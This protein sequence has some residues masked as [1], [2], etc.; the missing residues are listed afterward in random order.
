MNRWQFSQAAR[1]LH[2]GGLIAY[3]TE[4]VWGLGCDPLNIHSVERLLALKARPQ[5]KGLI[6]I[7]AELAQIAPFIGDLTLDERRM[8]SSSGPRAITW[9]VPAS[10]DCPPWLRGRHSTIAIRLTGHSLA[11]RL[12]RAFGGAI[13]ST[14]ANPSGLPAATRSLM[15]RR[16]FGDTIDFLCPGEL[17]GARRASEIRDL[18]SGAVIRAGG[19]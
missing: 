4:A 15:V 13:V 5:S 19:S 11:A 6:L 1:V 9:L 2:A 3:P 8:L 17:G 16:Y 10:E 14:S 18:R 7:A 12:C